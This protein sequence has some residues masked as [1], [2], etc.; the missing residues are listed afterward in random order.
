[1]FTIWRTKHALN[2]GVND[3]AVRCAVLR[4]RLRARSFFCKMCD[5]ELVTKEAFAYRTCSEKCAYD[6]WMYKSAQLK[7]L[8]L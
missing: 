2:R 7:L 4:S 3:T 5:A 1:M 6:D 8:F